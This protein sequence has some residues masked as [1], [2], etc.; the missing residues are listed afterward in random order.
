M[1]GGRPHH[2]V[3]QVEAQDAPLGFHELPLNVEAHRLD[4]RPPHSREVAGDPGVGRCVSRARVDDAAE[5]V[6]QT[7]RGHRA[8]RREQRGAQDGDRERDARYRMGAM[9]HKTRLTSLLQLASLLQRRAAGLTR[10]VAALPGRPSA[11]RPWSFTTAR[12]SLAM[13]RTLRRRFRPDAMKS[14]R[15]P[16]SAAVTYAPRSVRHPAPRPR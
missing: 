1:L 12:S 16:P 13:P 15:S 7:L 10:S 5:A 2:R 6:G 9:T 14:S 4:A 8:G 3:K 11:R